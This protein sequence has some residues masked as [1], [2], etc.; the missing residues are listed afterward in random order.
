MAHNGRDTRRTNGQRV[1]G[2][3]RRSVMLFRGRYAI[4][5]EGRGFIL[6]PWKPVTER[7]MGQQLSGTVRGHSVSWEV[8]R[9]PDV[10]R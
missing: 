3:Y 8:G 2:V 7:R 9:Q 1:A 5:V 6:V 4:L 10:S